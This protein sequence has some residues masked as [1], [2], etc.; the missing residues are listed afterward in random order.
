VTHSC[1]FYTGI[2]L[3]I[4]NEKFFNI[5]G[6]SHSK[7]MPDRPGTNIDCGELLYSL[8]VRN[9]DRDFKFLQMD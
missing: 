5:P 7:K 8:F 3:I 9:S 1:L 4:N 6:D 2:C